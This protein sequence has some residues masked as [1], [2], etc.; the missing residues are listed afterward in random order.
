MSFNCAK[1]RLSGQGYGCLVCK[2][3]RIAKEKDMPKK[4]YKH[5]VQIKIDCF[6]DDIG[7]LVQYMRELCE[8]EGEGVK[9]V[10][11][12]PETESMGHYYR[13]TPDMM[14]FDEVL[15]SK[16]TEYHHQNQCD[17]H[18][19]SGRG[20]KDWICPQCKREEI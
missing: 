14:G 2:S 8:V 18:K 7:D 10:D 19:L 3:E 16:P 11:S 9:R 17:I 5:A 12:M 20:I 6:Y 13:D 4:K 1:H 15:R